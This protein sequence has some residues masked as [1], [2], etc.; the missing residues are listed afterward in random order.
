MASAI[1]VGVLNEATDSPSTRL[2]YKLHI[3]PSGHDDLRI[4]RVDI[5]RLWP[6]QLTAM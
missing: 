5:V 1:L 3:N 4:D 2:A 6:D